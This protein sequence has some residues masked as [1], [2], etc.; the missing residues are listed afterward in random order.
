M[1]F[2]DS[3]WYTFSMKIVLTGGGTGGH[4]YPLIAVA[5]EINNIRD[6]DNLAKIDLYYLSND[7]YNKKLLYENSINYRHISSGKLRLTPSLKTIPDMFK[8][9]LGIL[10]AFF[11][12]FSLFPDVIFSKGGYA[13]F[14]TVFVARLLGIPVIVHES[15]SVPGRVNKWTGTFARSVAVSYKQGIDYF[16]KEKTIHTGQPI[17]HDLQQPAT[18]GA[19]EFL[20][21]DKN[22]P[23]IWVSGGSLGSRIINET[24][25]ESLSILLEKY[26]VVHQVGTKNLQ[27][28][29]KLTDATL[30]NSPYK[31]RYYQFGHL[32]SISMKMMASVADVIISRA[33][34]S[35]FEI[36]H[37]ELPSIIIPISHSH[38]N[39]QIK[40]AYNY[41]RAGACVVIE[42]NNL[43]DKL[44]IFEINRIYDNQDVATAMKDGAQRFA[45]K[46]AAEKIAKEIIA[47]TLSHEKK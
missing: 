46:D 33:G 1:P 47:I 4:F 12:L 26:Q 23:V 5:E 16:P 34:S 31:N 24:I 39:H 11:V 38:K 41:A 40:N 37:W 35:L 8:V 27:D 6:T 2:F 30:A 10:Q 44:L 32:N 15:D 28:M 43:S 20:G 29:K 19:Y 25:E 42:E 22:I 45:I 13:A 9:F 7:P 36:A 21:L 17:R 14:P 3:V 18:E